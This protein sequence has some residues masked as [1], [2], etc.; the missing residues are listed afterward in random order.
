MEFD[1]IPKWILHKHL[2]RIGTDEAFD[3]PMPNASAFEFL[4]GFVDILDS[5]RYVR[6]SR[7]FPFGTRDRRLAGCAKKMNLS[8]LFTS[9][10]INPETWNSGNLRPFRIRFQ[11][12]QAGVELV[13]LLEFVWFSSDTNTVVMQLDNFDGH[14]RSHLRGTQTAVHQ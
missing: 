9:A 12:E 13:S 7:I 5:Q 2:V 8:C 1:N 6:Q 10:D 4:T 14:L 3:A 11:A